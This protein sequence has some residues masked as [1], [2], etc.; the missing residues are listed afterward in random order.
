MKLYCFYGACSLAPH[1]AL[2]EAG[3]PVEP[4]KVDPQTR[5]VEGGGRLPEV[6]AKGYVPALVLDD[7]Q[8][9]TECVAILDWI[10]Q[11]DAALRPADDMARTRQ[12]E[13]LSFISTELHK[14]F[15]ALFFLPGDEAKPVLTQR[16]AERFAHVGERL[17]GDFL[18]GDRF[19]VADA[20]LYVMARW[21]S[22]SEMALPATFDAYVRRMETR[23]AVRAALAAEGLE[24]ALGGA[25]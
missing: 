2:R 17:Q 11:Q 10:A 18:L 25:R 15:L 6:N 5:E 4:V 23:P 9:L 7:G 16:I 12:I 19:G 22:M 3:L 13:A 21:A 24:P 8:M 1:I 20:F 14:Q